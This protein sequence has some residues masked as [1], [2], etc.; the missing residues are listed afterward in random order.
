M[1]LAQRPRSRHS[2]SQ[3][4]IASAVP[5]CTAVSQIPACVSLV[6]CLL[7]LGCKQCYLYE[8]VV[9]RQLH[10]LRSSSACGHAA[11]LLCASRLLQL[12]QNAA[13]NLSATACQPLA[14]LQHSTMNTKCSTAGAE[15]KWAA[16]AKRAADVSACSCLGPRQDAHTLVRLLPPHVCSSAG[17]PA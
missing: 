4:S 7:L 2:S 9:Y 16:Q 8:V 3:M 15:D 17:A 5:A 12:V 14:R 11:A 10:C 1:R 13:A 6:S